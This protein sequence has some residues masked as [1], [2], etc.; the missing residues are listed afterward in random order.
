MRDSKASGRWIVVALALATLASCGAATATTIVSGFN[1][2]SLAANDDLSTS[3]VMIGF[4]VNFFGTNTSSLYVNNNGNLTFTQPLS[5]FT[6][7]GLGSTLTLGFGP[8]IAPFFADVDT[9]VGN[10]ATYGTGTFNG[11]AA[12]GANWPNVG[13]FSGHTNKLNNFQTLLVDRVDTGAGNF[14]IYFNY[15]QIQWET[16][17]ASRGQNGLGGDCAAVGYTNGL[18]GAQ[19][20]SFNWPGSLVCNSFLDG[21]TAPLI[22]ATNDNTP[23]QLYFQV[24]NGNVVSPSPVPEPGTSMLMGSGILALFGMRRR[25][26]GSK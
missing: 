5:H 21:G 17:D 18:S 25:L 13:Y 26:F 14:D 3:Q 12:F 20:V 15:G 8:I 2:N 11:D 4:A 10:V 24:R 7:F 23:G 1:G 16:G 22:H 6:P 19:N 9:R